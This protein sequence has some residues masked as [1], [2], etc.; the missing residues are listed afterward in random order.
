MVGQRSRCGHIVAPPERLVLVVSDAEE[1]VEFPSHR[2]REHEQQAS[3]LLV[4]DA[5]GM[6]LYQFHQRLGRDPL[7]LAP[8][9]PPTFGDADD[10]VTHGCTRLGRTGWARRSRAEKGAWRAGKGEAGR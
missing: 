3:P 7:R 10:L 9:A 4:V 5:L 2:L 6:A 1:Q 8:P